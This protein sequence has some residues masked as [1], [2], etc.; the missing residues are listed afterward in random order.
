MESK[1]FGNWIAGLMIGSVAL[2]LILTLV[3]IW[4]KWFWFGWV[5]AGGC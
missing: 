5:M 4:L 3:G 2:L 1:Q